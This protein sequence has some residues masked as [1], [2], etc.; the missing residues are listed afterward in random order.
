MFVVIILSKAKISI[1]IIVMIIIVVLV[2]ASWLLYISRNDD[3]YYFSKAEKDD[4]ITGTSYRYVVSATLAG[5]LEAGEAVTKAIYISFGVLIIAMGSLS[6]FNS[7]EK[8]KAVITDR[9]EKQKILNSDI[10]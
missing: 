9:A 2:I 4:Y 6:L 3:D 1:S 8:T 10:K 5:N 7:I